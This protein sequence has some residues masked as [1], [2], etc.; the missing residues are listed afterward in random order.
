MRNAAFDS[1]F[2]GRSSD[3]LANGF[4]HRFRRLPSDSVAAILH[5]N[6]TSLGRESRQLGLQLTNADLVKSR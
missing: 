6:L 4:D 2:W 3:D 5:N 1:L